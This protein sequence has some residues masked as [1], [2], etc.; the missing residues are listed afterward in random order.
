MNSEK[1]I[2]LFSKRLKVKTLLIQQGLSFAFFK[3]KDTISRLLF[4]PYETITILM[5]T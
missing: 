3:D 5:M 2:A 4:C 1:A